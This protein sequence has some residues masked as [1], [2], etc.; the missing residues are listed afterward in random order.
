[1]DQRA[2]GGRADEGV[3]PETI[4]LTKVDRRRPERKIVDR[5]RQVGDYSF[6]SN[7]ELPNDSIS[8][9]LKTLQL[10]GQRGAIRVSE[11]SRELNIAPS[12]AHRLLNILRAHEFAEQDT[13]SRRYVLGPAAV[14]LALNARGDQGLISA[15][16]PHLEQLCAAIDET[17]NLVVLDGA[18]IVFIDG[19]EARQPLRIA[20]RTGA[21]IPAYAAAGGKVL[22]ACLPTASVQARY[23]KGL[24]QITPFTLTDLN[25]LEQDLETTRQAGFGINMGEHLLEINGVAVSVEGA[26]GTT[27]AALTVATP[28]SRWSRKELEALAPQL[29]EISSQITAD[30]RLPPSS[31][32]RRAMLATTE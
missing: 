24:D 20:T 13:R 26:A 1:V 19:V 2:E 28:S 6:M 12:T 29:E 17:V 5:G 4:C 14:R 15:A 27:I 18:D 21:R 9:S 32:Q 16:R 3:I 23:S 25:L 11:L 8:K 22:L 10:L 31:R 7:D 30:L